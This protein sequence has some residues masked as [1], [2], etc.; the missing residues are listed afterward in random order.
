MKVDSIDID[1]LPG[2]IF[3][4]PDTQFCMPEIKEELAFVLENMNI[5]PDKMDGFIKCHET[6]KFKC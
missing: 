2:V 6:G 1:S 3:Q 4:D 5:E